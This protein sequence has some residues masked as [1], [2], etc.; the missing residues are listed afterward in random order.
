MIL[1]VRIRAWHSPDG[2]GAC[3]QLDSAVRLKSP[4]RRRRQA[5]SRTRDLNRVAGSPSSI[6]RTVELDGGTRTITLASPGFAA[7]AVINY[8]TSWA[9]TLEVKGSGGTFNINR[10][11]A[12][13][14]SVSVAANAS[15]KIDSGATV[16]L[17]GV[18]V[19]TD[20]THNVAITNNGTFNVA[21]T[22]DITIGS[23]ISGT[24]D[25]TQTGPANT[26]LTGNYTATGN[27]TISNGTLAF[28][29]TSNTRQDTGVVLKMSSLSVGPASVLDV[30]NHDVIIGNTNIATIN[31]EIAN[32]FGFGTGGAA[33]TSSTGLAAGDTFLAPLDAG[34]FG[35]TSWDNVAIDQPNSI[36]LKYTYF[37]DVNFDGVVDSS[38]YA[39]L[40]Q[41]LGTGNSWATGDANLDG[42]VDS[43]DYAFLDQF[44]GS[45]VTFGTPLIAAANV[46]SPNAAVPEPASLFLLGL[47]SAYVLVKR[48]RRMM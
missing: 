21:N 37:G 46:A 5:H 47:G 27:I 4:I 43:S 16:S 10:S 12:A 32:G 29:N 19:L 33:I 28:A 15:I 41:N 13:P 30:T 26:T 8:T 45:G 1:R 39:L 23:N 22:S 48:K 25:L 20:G 6:A 17:S 35:I 36:I 14:G 9:G 40:D 18:N 44:V 31:A 11:F 24:G 3:L 42:T 2:I 38:D 34:A 7:G